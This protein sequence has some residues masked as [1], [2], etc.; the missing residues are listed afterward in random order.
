MLVAPFV[1]A[2]VSSHYE[3]WYVYFE[4][5]LFFGI[6]AAVALLGSYVRQRG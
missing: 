3:H 4:T 1:D 5:H 2:C 6:V